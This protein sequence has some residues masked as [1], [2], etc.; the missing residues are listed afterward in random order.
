MLHYHWVVVKVHAPTQSPLASWSG[1]GELITSWQEGM[2]QL[3]TQP[4]LIPPDGPQLDFASIG[5]GG[6]TGF[7]VMFGL[8]SFYVACPFSGPLLENA[9]DLG[10][11]FFC[12]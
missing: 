2:F 4:S 3:V 6:A 10:Y 9:F 5:V 8:S 12:A 1:V 11:L 7:S